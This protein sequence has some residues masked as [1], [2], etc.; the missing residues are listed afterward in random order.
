MTRDLKFE[1]GF[2]VRNCSAEVL[3]AKFREITFCE[4]KRKTKEIQVKPVF[5]LCIFVL[6]AITYNVEQANNNGELNL[7]QKIKCHENVR[8]V[9]VRCCLDF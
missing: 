7:A 3:T 9:R 8:T 1:T 2:D 4:E 5:F 6:F